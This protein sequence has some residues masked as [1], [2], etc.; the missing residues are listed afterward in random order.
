MS[1]YLEELSPGDLFVVND[2]HFI[3]TADFTNPK[4]SK[5]QR[6]CISV[7]NG[8]VSWINNDTIVATVDL[9][10]RDSDSNIIA[11]KEYKNE[12]KE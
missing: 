5:A 10:Y 7:T 1:K 6:M 2:N 4:S 9:Y 12:Y 11:L 8:F 3:L